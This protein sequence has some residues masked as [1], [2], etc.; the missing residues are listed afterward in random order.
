MSGDEY[1]ILENCPVWRRWEFESIADQPEAAALDVCIR[2]IEQII[3]DDQLAQ[4]RVSEHL[5]ARY[6]DLSRRDSDPVSVSISKD[7]SDD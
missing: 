6:R 5:A 1:K 7:E 2:A 4:R 3:P